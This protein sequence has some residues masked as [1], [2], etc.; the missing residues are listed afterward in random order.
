MDTRLNDEECQVITVA[1]KEMGMSLSAFA[2]VAA[3][4]LAQSDPNLIPLLRRQPNPRR[5]KPNKSRRSRA[6]DYRLDPY[7]RRRSGWLFL[8]DWQCVFVV[9]PIPHED[10][11]AA[12]TLGS[13]VQNT[14]GAAQ[15]AVDAR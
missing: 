12:A 13:A 5:T 8:G 10:E 9:P 14:L 15:N 6:A 4:K 11:A 1:A 3:M 2:R 7:R